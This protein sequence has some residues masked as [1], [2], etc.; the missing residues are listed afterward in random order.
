VLGHTSASDTSK[1][2]KV[3]SMTKL[4]LSLRRG[5][6]WISA[7]MERMPAIMGLVALNTCGTNMSREY[8]QAYSVRDGPK[9]GETWPGEHRT[10]GSETWIM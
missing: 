3:I 2:L 6:A 1:V 7:S 9:G 10:R 4:M 8:T 5:M